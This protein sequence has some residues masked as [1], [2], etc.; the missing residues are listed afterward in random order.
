MNPKKLKEILAS[1]AEELLQG[2]ANLENE[3]DLAVGDEE[4]LNSLLGVA[5]RVQS[6]LTSGHLIWVWRPTWKDWRDGL[7][8][9]KLRFLVNRKKAVSYGLSLELHFY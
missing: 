7:K 1:R 3:H 9:N 4:E 8:Q 5:E 2:R 6:T